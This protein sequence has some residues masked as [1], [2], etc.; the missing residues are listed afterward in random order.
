MLCFSDFVRGR[1]YINLGEA[2][3]TYFG[4]LAVWKPVSG[5]VPGGAVGWVEEQEAPV[6]CPTWKLCSKVGLRGRHDQP[7]HSELTFMLP[8]L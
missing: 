4:L 3:Y 5:W 6:Q 1:I 2:P 8:L 7:S